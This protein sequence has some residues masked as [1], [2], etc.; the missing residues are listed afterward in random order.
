[1][2]IYSMSVSVDGF[3]TDREGAFEWTV[4]SEELFRFH[5]V[6][7]SDLGGYL[8]GRRLYESMLVW[9][10]D[11]S[12][13]A[14]ELGAAFADLWCALPKIVFSRTLDSVQ[15]N[16]R[17]AEGSLAEEVAAALDATGKDV[18]IGGADLAAAAIELGLVGELRL[19]RY[20]VVVGGGTPFLPPVTEHVPLDLIETRRFGPRVIYERYGVP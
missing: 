5:T 10:T 6:L 9:E 3:I 12:L 16:A 19:F 18:G 20:P 17:L 15:G 13:R 1:M 4:P 8:L 14:N 7:V 2:L 11:P